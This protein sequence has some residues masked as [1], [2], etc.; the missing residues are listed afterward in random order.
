M[1]VE[2]MDFVANEIRNSNNPLTTEKQRTFIGSHIWGGFQHPKGIEKIKCAFP[3]SI[4][5]VSGSEGDIEIDQASK[6]FN[7]WLKKQPQKIGSLL[8][9]YLVNREYNN[10]LELLFNLGY[11]DKDEKHGGAIV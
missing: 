2:V 5:V 3:K 1:S 9:S 10:V 7:G 4:K 8:V 6:E 11:L